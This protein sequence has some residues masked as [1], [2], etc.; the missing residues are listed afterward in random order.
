[1]SLIGYDSAHPTTANVF[2]NVHVGAGANGHAT[3]GLGVVASLGAD[4]DWELEF[5]MPPTLPT[6]TPKLWARALANAS[7]GAAKWN[8]KCGSNADEEDA[9]AITLT[10]EGTQT[11]TWATGDEDVSKETKLTLDAV[12]PVGGETYIIHV[13]ME[14]TGW[15]LAQISTWKFDIIWE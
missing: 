11:T 13:T 5:P 12:A 7:S 15:T 3:R 1:M 14:T 10:A 6:G 2:P 9:S 4:A 8:P